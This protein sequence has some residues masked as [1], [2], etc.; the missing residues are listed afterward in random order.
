M[1]TASSVPRISRSHARAIAL[2]AQGLHEPASDVAAQLERTGFVRTVGGVDAYLAIRARVPSTTRAEIDALLAGGEARVIPAVRG[3]I[4]LVARSHVAPALRLAALLAE[5]RERREHAKAGIEAGEI[6]RVAAA[7]LDALRDNGPSTT[8]ALRRHLP[9]G[10]VRSL[11]ATGK[12]VGISSTLPPA[13]RRLEFA[14]AIER[15]NEDGRLDNE[16]YQWRLAS[17]ADDFAGADETALYD[18]IGEV[19]LRAA[20]VAT[21]KGLAAWAGIKQGDAK[22]VLER[23]PVVAVEIEAATEIDGATDTYYL[24]AERE[25]WLDRPPEVAG[26]LAFVTFEDNLLALHDG[27]AFLT[28]SRHHHVEVPKWGRAKGS[29]LGDITHTLARTIVIDGAIG[30]FWEYDPDRQEVVTATLEPAS[31]TVVDR[32]GSAAAD[33]GAFIRDQLGHGQSFSLD[34]DDGLR[35][36]V[37]FVES[38][39]GK[40]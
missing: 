25:S 19:Y 31:A 17:H 20:G 10:V 23:L 26:S 33:P 9:V 36:R 5:P 38:L 39:S 13:L 12:K 15:A 14:G 40:V 2:A 4:Y 28:E 27:P 11:G 30:G 32:L 16:R 29:T 6:D 24:L 18:A 37:A 22:A 3:C 1:P 7:V 34:T 35:K 8:N 21:R